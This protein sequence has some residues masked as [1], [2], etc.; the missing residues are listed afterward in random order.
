[1]TR[2]PGRCTKT[3]IVSRVVADRA[4]ELCRRGRAYVIK[5]HHGD[6]RRPEI[7]VVARS[8]G[9]EAKISAKHAGPFE[10]F[11]VEHGSGD[12]LLPGFDQTAGLP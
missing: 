12:G 7:S 11:L 5:T 6:G 10:T 9:Y 4:L 3:T 2:S 1:M 8:S